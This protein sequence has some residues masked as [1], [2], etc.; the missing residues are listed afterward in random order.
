MS[1]RVL[2]VVQFTV[3]VCLVIGTLVVYQQIQFA[4]NRP[5]GYSSKGMLQLRARSPEYFGK[6]QVLRTELKN[7]GVVEEIAEANYPVTSF[8]GWNGG[9]SWKGQPIAPTFNTIFVTPEYGKTVGLEVTQGRDFSREF[10]SDE[11]GILLNESA[12][13]EMG[14]KNPV[15]EYLTWAPGGTPRGTY[16][17]LGVVK[18]MVKGSPFDQTFSSVI[19]YAKNDQEWLYIR[20][21]P[22]VSPHEALPKIKEVY[23]RLIPSAP[24]DY[25]FSDEEYA[26]KF[27]AEERVGTLAGIFSFLAILISCSGLFGLASFTAEQRTKEIS[28]RKVLGAS[29]TQVWQL[30]SKEFVV[31]VIISCAVAIPLSA[32]FMERW[33][34]QYQYRTTVG[35]YVF[36]LAGIG[37]LMITLIT[38]SF[39]AIKA[40][41]SNPVDSLKTE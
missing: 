22:D 2:V 8:L 17:I 12:V 6:Y 10:Q 5:T 32:M 24:F 35:W 29:V 1:R 13:K 18:D 40:A 21:K 26:V 11:S 36:A 3:S 33:L 4:K 16:Q 23:T 41:V 28:I 39:Q 20:M 31:L 15:G 37:S 14:L 34:Q 30:M 19:F 9:F 7:T 38:V 27:R 25:N